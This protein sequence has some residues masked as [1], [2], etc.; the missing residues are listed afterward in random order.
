MYS[1]VCLYD[2]SNI[3]PPFSSVFGLHRLRIFGFRHKQV[4]SV[5][6]IYLLYILLIK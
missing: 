4:F 6:F 2:V 3:Q 5:L 1:I